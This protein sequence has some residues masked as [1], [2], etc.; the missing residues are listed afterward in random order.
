MIEEGRVPPFYMLPGPGRG[1]SWTSPNL[2]TGWACCS[3]RMGAG[4]TLD[5]GFHD[6]VRNHLP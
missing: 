2:G 3:E 1:C 5:P 6:W 4:I